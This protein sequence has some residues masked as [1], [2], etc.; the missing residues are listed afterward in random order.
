MCTSDFLRHAGPTVVF[1]VSVPVAATTNTQNTPTAK[2]LVESLGKHTTVDAFGEAV[3]TFHGAGHLA[4]TLGSFEPYELNRLVDEKHVQTLSEQMANEKDLEGFSQRYPLL[5]VAH[6]I[7]DQEKLVSRIRPTWLQATISMA[8]DI[9]VTL[10]D[11][12]HRVLAAKNRGVTYW[13]TKVMPLGAPLCILFR[14]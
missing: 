4:M 3:K 12:Q 1:T 10:L 13:A 9:P 11:G 7:E 5:V 6:N 8:K 2:S 14:L